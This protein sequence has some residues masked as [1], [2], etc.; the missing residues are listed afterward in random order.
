MY[1]KINVHYLFFPY[2]NNATLF[3]VVVVVVV[4]VVADDLIALP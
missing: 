1:R 4:V 2:C 3:T